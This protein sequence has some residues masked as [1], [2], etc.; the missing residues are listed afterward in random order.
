MSDNF[1][2]NN[3]RR[4]QNYSNSAYNNTTVIATAVASW[5]ANCSATTQNIDL[6]NTSLHQLDD[7]YS[8]SIVGNA[9]ISFNVDVKN[10]E[11]YYTGTAGLA[12]NA[13]LLL[14][15]YAVN[16]NLGAIGD[17]TNISGLFLNNEPLGT[18]SA[19]LD[20]ANNAVVIGDSTLYITVRSF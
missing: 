10:K 14:A 6:V 1:N 16:P 20:I 12:T 5:S 11:I 8:I 7:N 17:I 13:Y 2:L 18:Y 19:R 15:T 9:S 3:L 4:T